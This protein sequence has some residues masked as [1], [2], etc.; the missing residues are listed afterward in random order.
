MWLHAHKLVLP[1][2]RVFEAP[3]PPELQAH[4]ELLQR[5]GNAP[6]DWD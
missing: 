3:L 4:L 1:D 2:D 6:P 5:G